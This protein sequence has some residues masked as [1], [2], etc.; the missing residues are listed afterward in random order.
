MRLLG[1]HVRDFRGFADLRLEFEPDVTVLVGVNGAGKTSLL[2]AIGLLLS[3]VAAGV[4][5]GRAK[6]TLLAPTDV[7]AGATTASIA[8]AAEVGGTSATWTVARTRPGYPAE[9]R[10]SLEEL[11]PIIARSQ[12]AIADRSPA[13]PLAVYFPTNRNA[14]DIPQRIRTPHEF[15]A[16]SAYDGALQG[17][18]RNFRG[19]F[20]WYREEEDVYNEQRLRGS[21][22]PPSRLPE[23]RAAI[24]ALFPG[25]R[26]L[27]I[28]R[29]PQRMTL[30][31][32]GVRLDVA[33]LSDGEKCLLALA[34]DLARRLVL[35]APHVPRP[36]EE[37]AVV[38]IDEIELHLHPGLQRTIVPQLRQVFPNAQ[39]VVSTHSPQVLSSVHAGS[40]RLLDHFQLRRLQRGTWHRDTNRILDEAFGD[41]GRPPEVA[42]RLNDLRD[43]VDH[44]R[45]AEARRLIGELRGMIEGDD[46]DVYF[47]EQLL[48]PEAGEEGA[49]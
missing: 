31:H 45:H 48:Q 22:Q 27:R 20:E 44:D 18:A 42:R 49:E 14:L 2:D 21:D 24:E 30:E 41:P 28:E 8:L 39:F 17:G 23:V 7:R 25:A 43:A 29:K 35:A 47:L 34:G 26:D 36:L 33:Q 15:D 10:S 6:G 1:L 4:R 9:E 12:R 37:P 16:L 3:Y 13:L 11:G 5:T 32:G 19:F 46:P 40:V 38:M